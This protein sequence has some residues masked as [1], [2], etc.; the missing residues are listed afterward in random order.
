MN[1]LIKIAVGVWLLVTSGIGNAALLSSNNGFLSFQPLQGALVGQPAEEF[2]MQFGGMP[3]FGVTGDIDLF[4]L[5][6]ATSNIDQTFVS[7]SGASFNAVTS[8]LT[9]GIDDGIW[10][11][12][13]A[14]GGPYATAA[15]YESMRF[16]NNGSSN[17][18]DFAGNTITGLELI[19]HQ[20]DG[21]RYEASYTF[22]VYGV[23]PVP[24]P[25]A[26]WLL[27]SGLIT[28]VGLG[29]RNKKA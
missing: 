17:G 9:N 24:I 11:S 15:G 21:S 19:M 1:H 10:L 13:Y 12:F 4:I 16:A 3:G 2:R 5:S 20:I 18:I 26:V 6:A 27:S 28:L 7:T 22:N 29:R 8:L 23:T 25:P 14:L